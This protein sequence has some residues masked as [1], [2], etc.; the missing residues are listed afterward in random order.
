MLSKA[1]VFNLI[2]KCSPW[3][4]YTF[5]P[6]TYLQAVNRLHN[7][8]AN[9]L[10]EY[11]EEYITSILNQP[12]ML[13]NITRIFFL[14]RLLFVPQKPG[15]PF[16][17]IRVGTPDDPNPPPAKDFPIYPLLLIEDVPLLIVAGFNLG[18]LPQSPL[19]HLEFCRKECRVRPAPL[20]PPANPL[21]LA[22][23][24]LSSKQ[25]YREKEGA[26]ASENRAILRAQ[27][28]RLVRSAYPL[29]N[30][31]DMSFFTTLENDAD[32]KNHL[33]AFERLKATWDDSKNAY[34]PAT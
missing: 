34:R 13:E 28:L 15:Q 9:L 21:P 12:K 14:L 31:D 4:G 19:E 11:L 17:E 2:E 3:D 10:L 32:W 18:G 25:W 30:V 24:L 5:D 22:D 33:Q 6:A 29:P 26:E 8:D 23:Q 20:H 27:L 16:P 1:D 7:Q